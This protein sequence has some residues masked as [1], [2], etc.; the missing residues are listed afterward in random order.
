VPA[1]ST[2]LSW[3]HDAAPV[4]SQTPRWA[5][6]HCGGITVTR[7]IFLWHPPRMLGL[8]KKPGS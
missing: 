7:G 1:T 3:G 4:G 2:A 6:F 5:P 8:C